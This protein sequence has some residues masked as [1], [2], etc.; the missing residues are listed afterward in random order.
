MDGGKMFISATTSDYERIIDYNAEVR[1][2][3]GEMIATGPYEKMQD[4]GDTPQQNYIIVYYNDVRPEG[5]TVSLVDNQ[6]NTLLT[7]TPNK[8]YKSAIITTD[9]LVTGNKYTIVSG[10]VAKDIVISAGKNELR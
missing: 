10:D 5:S 8:F 2:T 4:L 7:F 3:G 6:G 1:L 9:K